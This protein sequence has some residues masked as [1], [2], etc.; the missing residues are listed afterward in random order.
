MD[1]LKEKGWARLNVGTP[2]TYAPHA[3]GNFLTPSGRCEFK[4]SMAAG[5]NFVLLGFIG[6]A[7]FI[8]RLP[9][10]LSGGQ[11]RR[12]AIARA[13]AAK[14][15][16]LLYD[17]PTTGLDPITAT[18]VDEEIVKL[19]DVEGISSILANERGPTKRV[20]AGVSMTATSAPLA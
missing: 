12:V 17:E 8:D 19:R 6:L 7:E 15:R 2:E 3:N 20:A 11:R 14:P 9:S 5:G 10:E 1:L 18:T 16:I 13:M 4:A